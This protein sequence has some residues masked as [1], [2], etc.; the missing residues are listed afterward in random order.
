M[1]YSNY[2]M[3]AMVTAAVVYLLAVFAH[4]AEWASAKNASAPVVRRRRLRDRVLVGAGAAG[5]DTEAPQDPPPAEQGESEKD[6]LRTDKFGRI[7][8]ALTV[9]ALICNVIGVVL[10]GLAADRLPWGN[11]YEF[12]TTSMIFAVTAYLVAATR[13]TMRWLGLPVTMFATIALGLAVTVFYVDIGPLQPSLHSIWFAFHILAATIAGAAFTV[14]GAASVLYLIR[15]RAEQRNEV[16]RGYLA[17]LPSAEKIDT[18]AYSLLAF[19]FPLFTFVICAGAIW[20][21]YAWGRYWGWDPKETWSLVTW[22]IYACYLHARSTAGWKGKRAAI[23]A[24]IGMVSFW[25]NFVGINL[26]V[27]GLHSYAK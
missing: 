13:F 19:A 11:M 24:I 15:S 5:A 7:G 12:S 1:D 10:R 3:L 25:W 16:I 8:I 2:S 17:K 18:V 21:Q 14:G 22:V 26:L 4:A 27:S 6:R 9:V 20:A 23:I